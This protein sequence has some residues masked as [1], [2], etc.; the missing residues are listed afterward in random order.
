MPGYRSWS[1]RA[2]HSW[3]GTLET[4]LRQSLL[5]HLWI[6]VNKAQP[7]PHGAYVYQGRT[8]QNK[9]SMQWRKWGRARC[10]G[11]E[12]EVPQPHGIVIR[13]TVC[14]LSPPAPGTQ[15]ALAKQPATSDV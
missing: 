3:R 9:L 6:M 2:H 11:G 1:S 15:K 10:S 13:H 12:P 4:I 14:P 7:L 8:A 5:I